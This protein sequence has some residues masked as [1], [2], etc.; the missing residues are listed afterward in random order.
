MSPITTSQPVTYGHDP[1][2][3]LFSQAQ[4]QKMVEVGILGKDDKVELLEGYV[5]HRTMRDPAHNATLHIALHT[6]GRLLPASLEY[7]TLA[8]VALPDSQPEPGVSVVRGPANTYMNRYPGPADVVLVVEVANRSLA[9]DTV[10]KARI[11][12]RAGIPCYWVIDLVA[13]AVEVYT[14]P[15]GPTAVPAFARRVTVRPP[16]VICL[17]LDGTT[18]A[19]IAAAELLP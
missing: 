2:T 6:L 8:S 19:Q 1:S 18:I 7:R 16:G 3:Y 17:V 14:Q 10:D 11:Y 9:R 13:G 5:V 12:A 4:Y 15:S